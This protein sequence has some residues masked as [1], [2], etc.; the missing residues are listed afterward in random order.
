M[1][2]STN[3][4]REIRV[5]V[6]LKSFA[7]A[8]PALGPAVLAVITFII[9]GASEAGFYPVHSE[10]Q[11]GLGWYP[12]GVLVLALLAT[13]I[14]TAR[15]RAVPRATLVAAGLLAGFAAWSLLSI[16]WAEAQGVAWDGANRAI[17]YLA[18]FCLFA[19]WPFSLGGARLLLGGLALG[20]AGIGVVELLRINASPTP[21]DF[22]IDG[23]LTEPT[24]YVNA[25]VAL[26]MLG[27][28]PCLYLTGVRSVP[29]PIRGIALGG[30][31]VLGALPVLTQSR[32]WALALPLA[33]I[34]YVAVTPRRGRALASIGAVALAVALI[35]T[36]LLA[37]HDEFSPAHLDTLLH[38]AIS[39]IFAIAAVL[40]VLGTLAGLAD[41][42]VSVGAGLSRSIDRGATLPAVLIVV[43][44]LGAAGVRAGDPVHDLSSSW[45]SFK[46]GGQGGTAGSSRFTSVGTNRYDF[47]TVA[48]HLFEDHPLVGIG[49]ANFQQDYLVKGHS[50]EQP[51]YPHSLGLGILSQTG[52]IGAL[53][54]GGSLMCAAVAVAQRR[55]AGPEA[56]AAAA[57]SAT[58]FGYWLLHGSIDWFWEFPGLTAPA[59]AMLGL[60]CAVGRSKDTRAPARAARPVRITAG[61]AS[62]TAAIVV[63]ASMILPWLAER[64]TEQAASGWPAS[65]GTAFNRLGRA[66]TLNPLSPDPHLTAALIAI[67]TEDSQR[68]A[69][70]LRKVVDR[71]PRTP[72]AL[73]EQAAL[74][75]ERGDRGR[76]GALIQRAAAYSPRDPTVVSARKQIASGRPF[77]IEKLNASFL[78]VARQREI[79]P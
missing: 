2:T 66:A 14:V 30:A 11:A 41:H 18:S 10:S 34:L 12:A 19:L 38:T 3:L 6:G 64:E 55:R 22:F 40:A 45:Q 50:D 43:A 56:A 15:P 62:V 16:G 52:L 42:R 25:N 63:G 26:W 53:L 68:A 4:A 75:Y 49:S 74:A 76:A 28:W 51:R 9:L 54:L 33:V 23:R 79:T 77:G 70:E 32:G 57:A 61:V 65:P 78:E 35:S 7:R 59:F 48:W 5:P 73:A 36:P 44:A 8:N 17:I 60:A 72:F 20:I 67:R 71:E 21:V 39:R 47:W 1:S 27:F 46:T 24:G 37:V 58:V 29:A 69:T 31:G 13:A